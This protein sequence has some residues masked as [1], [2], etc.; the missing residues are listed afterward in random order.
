MKNYFFVILF[1]SLFVFSCKQT[2]INKKDT[3]MKQE[4]AYQKEL[5]KYF[6]YELTADLSNLSENQKQMLPLLFQV[7]D[8]MDDLYW[9]VACGDYHSI[10]D[11]LTDEAAKKLFMIN[12]GPWNRLNGNAPFIP[13][14]GK[15]PAGAFFYPADMTKEE[16]EAFDDAAKTDLYTLIRRDSAGNLICVPYHIA[17]V[18]ELNKAADLLRQAAELADDEGFKKYL[19][20]RADA[21]TS[22]DYF[23][24]DMA[25]MDMKDNVIEFVVGPIENYEDGLFEYKTA[26][27]AFIL[28]KDLQWSE[29]LAKYAQLLPDLQKQL[30]VPD[31][32]KKEEPGTNSQLNA[33]D[34]VYYAGDCNA[35]SKTIA[36][37]LPNDEKVQLAKGSRRLQLKN[38]MRA[39]F[40]SIVIPISQI[41]IDSAQRQYVTFDGFFANTMFHEVA[42]G[43]GIK[44]TLDGTTTCRE[45]LKERYS[46]FEE[47]KADILG[48]WLINKLIEMNEYQSNYIENQVTFVASIFRSIRFGAS[49]S[50]AKANLI[51]YNFFMEQGAIVRN[52]NGTYTINPEKVQVASDSLARLIITIQ[53]DGDYDKAGEIMD[54]YM[55]MTDDLKADLQRLEDANIPVDVTWKQGVDVLGL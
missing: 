36:I 24:S 6:E 45:A 27:E 10:Y 38:S 13:G 29:R 43:L 50:H 33:Y 53:G 34:A 22:D 2:D 23:E 49:S 40:D 46:T 30:P 14:V 4:N 41:L 21:L 18:D 55:I 3:E 11:T 44:N 47:G 15:K 32:Y 28:I 31:E 1:A 37:N 5:N 52:E 25:W 16:F 51:R 35:G 7:A 9:Q 39:K 54:K 19:Q 17:F 48:L 42:H 12:Y 8:I 26:F 20:L